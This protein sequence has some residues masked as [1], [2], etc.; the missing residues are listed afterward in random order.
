M[1]ENE[2]I[3]TVLVDITSGRNVWTHTVMSVTFEVTQSALGVPHRLSRDVLH[4]LAVH[5]RPFLTT[6]GISADLR[7]GGQIQHS[8]E[9]TYGAKINH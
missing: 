5:L 6:G 1:T 9:K 8:W 7:H 2:S 3:H 4:Q